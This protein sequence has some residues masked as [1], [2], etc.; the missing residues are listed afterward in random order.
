[1]EYV[2]Q[3][4]QCLVHHDRAAL[5]EDEPEVLPPHAASRP[6]GEALMVATGLP[7]I[8]PPCLEMRPKSSAFS[9]TAV[10]E[11]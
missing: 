10:T 11:P 6:A 7:R 1:M 2:R 3:S 8:G 4:D 5:F 9:R